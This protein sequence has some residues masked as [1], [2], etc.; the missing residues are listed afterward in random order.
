MKR[1]AKWSGALLALALAAFLI[2]G[3]AIS[4]NSMIGK[5]FD[6]CTSA[7]RLCWVVRLVISQPA[8]TAWIS[9]PRFDA[10]VADQRLRKVGLRKGA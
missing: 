7:T 8:P 10:S 2:F 9:P 4:E 3:P 6:A 1:F 5:V